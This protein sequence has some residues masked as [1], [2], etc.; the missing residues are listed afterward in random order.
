VNISWIRISTQTT[1]CVGNNQVSSASAK[2]LHESLP[3][4]HS[5]GGYS[6]WNDIDNDDIGAIHS[7]SSLNNQQQ[8]QQQQQQQRRY[9]ATT[10][11]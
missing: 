11:K 7:S 10:F 5:S 2:L 3:T 9:R 6:S 1:W 8:Q 4:I